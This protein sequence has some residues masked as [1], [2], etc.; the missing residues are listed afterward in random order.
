LRERFRHN[1][2]QRDYAGSSA[3][4]RSHRWNVTHNL[5]LGEICTPL[6]RL[7]CPGPL[8]RIALECELING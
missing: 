5:T 7:S 1:D 2:A 3:S 6:S 8:H 4:A